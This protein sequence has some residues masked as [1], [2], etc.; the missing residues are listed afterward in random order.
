MLLAHAEAY[1]AFKADA[2]L[3][4]NGATIGITNNC[5]FTEPASNAPADLAAAERV[6]EWWLGWF[7]DPIWLGHYPES[8][9][10]KL[11]DRL[12]S[13]TPEE[14]AKLKGS[15]DFFGLNHYGSR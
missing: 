15:S 3:T 14:A 1:E 11:G 2:T 13:F 7:A 4:A 10:R 6:N 8:M 5:D 12:P 9:V